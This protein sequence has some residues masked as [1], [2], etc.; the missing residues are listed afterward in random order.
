MG[1][2]G[3]RERHWRGHS[4]GSREYR[5]IVAAMTAAGIATFA[6]LYAVQAVLPGMAETFSAS[7]SRVALSVSFAT[8][9]LAACVLLWSGLADRVG[10]VR[11]MTVSL[12]AATLLGL[13]APLAPGMGTL[14]ALRAAQGAAL[15]GVPA[16]AMAYLAEEVNPRHLSR[17]AGAYIAG[18]TVGGMAG[19]LV[20]G[21]VSD[22]AGWRW[23][24]GADSLLG[25]AALALFLTAVPR[26]RGF[27]PTRR[28]GSGPG[29]ARRL[30]DS[31]TDPG[32]VALYCQALFLMGGFVTVYNYLGFRMTG[33]EFGLSQTLVA[34]LFVTYLAGTVSSAA[35][36][37][38]TERTGRHTV[39]LVCV[40]MMALGTLALLGDSLAIV[41][42]GLLV[43]TFFFFAAHATAS[44]W[45]GHRAPANARAQAGA[46]YTLSYYLG[47][48]GFGWLGG[49]FYDHVGWGGVVA[50]VVALCAAAALAGLALVVPRSAR[51]R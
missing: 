3:G 2:I 42:P 17:A 46:L 10:R 48:S 9:G 16:V 51:R 40:V 34:F 19:R 38:V 12:G 25:L 50:Y 35:V 30:R 41:V 49:V 33:G 47:S 8:G 45:V 23:G 26:P 5:R 11:V 7:S 21:V 44:G 6:Q 27:R 39:L 20:A 32:L 36:G 1:D 43:L 13:A 29:L 4:A 14:L 24:I 37:R 28:R 22:V 18:N 15:G 31:V